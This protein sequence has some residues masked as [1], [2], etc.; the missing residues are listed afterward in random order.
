MTESLLYPTFAAAYVRGELLHNGGILQDDCPITVPQ[1]VLEKPL[2]ELTEDE[3]QLLLQ[4][5]Q[6]ADLKLYRFKRTHEQLPRVKRVLG[7]LKGQQF[8]SILDVG[9]GRGVFLWPFM[10][11]FPWAEVGSLD[12]LNYRVDFLKRAAE[13][14]LAQLHPMQG[15]LCHCP[16]ISD[17]SHDIVTMLEVLEHIPDTYAALTSAVRIA[18]KGLVI[19][20][21]NQPD[22]NPEHIHL[23]TRESMTDALHR[24]GCTKISF[25]AVPGH[26]IVFVQIEQRAGAEHEF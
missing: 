14:G 24:V 3:T 21:P 19:S 11:I 2:R 10:S 4:V 25:D 8:D 17:K 9:S 5:G 26:W 16:E 20:V 12:L 1:A 18:R 7:Y 6:A 23:F 22:D 15:D 13:G